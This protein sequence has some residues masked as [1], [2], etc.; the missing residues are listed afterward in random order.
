MVCFMFGFAVGFVA[1]AI[2]GVILFMAYMS[3]IG[4][5]F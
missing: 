2:V 3:G 1:A 5:H 4:P